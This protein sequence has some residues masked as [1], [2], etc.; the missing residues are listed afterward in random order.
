[1]KLST[2]PVMSHVL[3]FA[4]LVICIVT[5]TLPGRTQAFFFPRMLTAT[6]GLNVKCIRAQRTAVCAG[7]LCTAKNTACG[8]GL[9]A[10]SCSARASLGATGR[11]AAAREDCKSCKE[12]EL[13]EEERRVGKVAMWTQEDEDALQSRRAELQEVCVI[14]KFCIC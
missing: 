14:F 1:M 13:S 4:A 8:R 9:F 7:S 10:S 11:L 6:S 12:Q 5:I 2:R 3:G